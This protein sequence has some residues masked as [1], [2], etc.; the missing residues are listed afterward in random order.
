VGLVVSSA[1]LVAPHTRVRTWWR[2]RTGPGNAAPTTEVA[3]VAAEFIRA[4][5]AGQ[6]LDLPHPGGGRTLERFEAL[7]ALGEL[8]LTTGRLA[9]AHTDAIAIRTE[10]GVLRGP[11][12]GDEVWGVWAAEPPNAQVLARRDGNEWLLQGRK[13]WC[14]GAGACTHALVTAKG[15]DGPRLF[16]VDLHRTGVTLV[17]DP[18][19]AA[20]LSGTDTRSVD[21]AD[22]TAAEVGGPRDYLDRPGF[23]HG[24][25]GVAAVWYGGAVGIASALRRAAER[26]EFGDID[27]VHLGAVDASLWA[28]RAALRAAAHEIEADPTDDHGTA[29]VVA[30]RTRAVV[31]ATV[32][33]VTDRVARALG[34]TPLALD[35]AHARRVADLALYVRQSHADRDLA[36]LARRL[37]ACGATW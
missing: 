5:V 8:D 27:L 10:L 21:F 18:W 33:A 12:S 1:V 34:P 22:A 36:D 16:A 31:E 6:I 29:A 9:E 37:L 26:R 20:A 15:Q 3:S 24:A 32:A 7:A 30:L 17:D 23:W 11:S 14:S 28:G 4:M 2:D 19:P 35:G 13:A 25:V